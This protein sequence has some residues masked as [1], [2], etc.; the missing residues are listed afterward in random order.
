MSKYKLK[1]GS[2][3]E[4]PFLGS[5]FIS[6]RRTLVRSH[7]GNYFMV[8]DAIGMM[9]NETMIFKADANGDFRTDDLW[10]TQP[11]NHELGIRVALREAF[12]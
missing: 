10:V 9:I 5:R 3:V 7:K 8:S 4:I 2:T 6:N 11:V 12:D 1:K